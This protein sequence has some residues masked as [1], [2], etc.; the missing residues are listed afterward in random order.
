MRFGIKARR[1]ALAI[2]CA[3]L[4][5]PAWAGTSWD[6]DWWT[7]DGGGEIFASGGSWEL[8][9]SVGQWDATANAGASGGQWELTGG[10]WASASGESDRL[11]TDGFE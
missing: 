3:L 2:A 6:I 8:S 1:A 7:V 4:I 10:F 11:F 5:A 9:G